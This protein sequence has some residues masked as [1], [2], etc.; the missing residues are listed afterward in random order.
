MDFTARFT[1][2]DLEDLGALLRPRF[3]WLRLLTSNI[4]G[5]GIVLVLIWV[6]LLGTLGKSDLDRRI[7]AGIWVALFTVFG[8][9]AYKTKRDRVKTLAS[10]NASLPD[11]TTFTAD[12]VDWES[13]DRSRGF[14]PWAYFT[15]F[16]EHGGVLCLDKGKR[17][18]E[19]FVSVRHVS[20]NERQ[21]IRD[22]LLSHVPPSRHG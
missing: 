19:V 15:G 4:H 13:A 11:R 5:A 14:L 21:Q 17:K 3:Y 18:A 20:A 22:F 1:K 8:A 12:G 10:L 16:R 2:E 7:V 6:A 9:A